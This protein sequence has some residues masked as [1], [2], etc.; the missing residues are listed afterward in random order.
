MAWQPDPLLLELFEAVHKDLSAAMEAR[1]RLTDDLA[2]EAA[3]LVSEFTMRIATLRAT[4][5][6]LKAALER[7]NTQLVH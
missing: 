5:T 6:G 4:I 2:D 3:G 7:R 1:Q